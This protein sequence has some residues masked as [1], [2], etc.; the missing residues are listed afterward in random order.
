MRAEY[1]VVQFIANPFSGLCF[2]V[3]ALVR[4]TIGSVRVVMPKSIPDPHCL[5]SQKA[6]NALLSMTD[7]LAEL[8]SF[9]RL[10]PHF[11]PHFTLTTPE[12]APSDQ[13]DLWVQRTLFP[14]LGKAIAPRRRKKG[15]AT[16]GKRYLAHH[17]IAVER[18]YRP[19]GSA[20][21]P[22]THY[23][24]H[25]GGLF[26]LEPLINRRDPRDLENDLREAN[27]H[28]RAMHDLLGSQPAGY[29]TYL[30]YG[31]DPRFKT[32]V[33]ER[34]ADFVNVVDTTDATQEREFLAALRPKE[35]LEPG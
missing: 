13:P 31:M 5:G 10:P 20:V 3:A 26:L 14:S 25:L 12:P 8:T 27:T 24:E 23:V 22:V 28:L 11:G 19:E 16:T 4:D 2:P 35:L 7:D 9:E 18:H 6:A 33:Q 15:R 30:L 1:R 29:F 17:G 34:V 21:Q 32:I